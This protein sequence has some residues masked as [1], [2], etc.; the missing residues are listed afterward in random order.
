MRK[1]VLIGQC[2]Y[3]YE[4]LTND[5]NCIQLNNLLADPLNNLLADPFLDGVPKHRVEWMKFLLRTMRNE[6]GGGSGQL[7]GLT[8]GQMGLLYENRFKSAEEVLVLLT[9]YDDL[10]YRL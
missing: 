10:G 7:R 4:A 5:H 1:N 6:S 9:N 3:C 8:K 2:P